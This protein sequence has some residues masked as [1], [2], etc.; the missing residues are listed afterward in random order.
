MRLSGR[1][2]SRNGRTEICYNNVWFGIC[3]DNYNNYNNPNTICGVLGYSYQGIN[4]TIFNFYLHKIIVD[5]TWYSSSFLDLPNLPLIPYEFSC[6]GTEQ[7]LLDCNKYPIN[8]YSFNSYY[9]YVYLGVT[10][11]GISFFFT[12]V[13]ICIFCS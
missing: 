5:A 11:Q 8:C 10:C 2:S 9:Y 1:S 13:F 6:S 7:S 4:C 12:F 3:A